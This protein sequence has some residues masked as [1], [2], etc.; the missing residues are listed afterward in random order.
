MKLESELILENKPE[1]L[2]TMLRDYVLCGGRCVIN[3]R[4]SKRKKPMSLSAFKA[5]KNHITEEI[6][7][8]KEGKTKTVKTVNRWLDS[9][10]RKS[11]RGFKY[12]P[13]DATFIKD[14]DGTVY[15]NTCQRR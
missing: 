9:P 5:S 15:Y 7:G 13:S 3:L 10:L 4:E 14:D 8:K 12:L 2:E 6:P 11:V 1:T